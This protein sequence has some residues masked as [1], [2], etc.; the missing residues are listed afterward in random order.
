MQDSLFRRHKTLAPRRTASAWLAPAAT[1]AM[2]QAPCTRW[3]VRMVLSQR[4]SRHARVTPARVTTA[5]ARGRRCSGR[6]RLRARRCSA[7]LEARGSRC[8]GTC[9]GLCEG[10]AQ[11]STSERGSGEEG[12]G[13]DEVSNRPEPT[14]GYAEEVAATPSHTLTHSL[15]HSPAH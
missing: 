4:T 1:R 9:T 11:T 10:S 14:L 5:A 7:S 8:E 15:T 13:G 6:N 2:A 12:R 3:L